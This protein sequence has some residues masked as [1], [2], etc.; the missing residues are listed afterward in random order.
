MIFIIFNIAKLNYIFNLKEK[1]ISVLK[2]PIE[3]LFSIGNLR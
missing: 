2:L 3:N 1:I